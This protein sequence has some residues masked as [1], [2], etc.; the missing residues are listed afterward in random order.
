MYAVTIVNQGNKFWLKGTT[1]AFSLER[2][3]QFP[4]EESARNQLEKAKKFM[5][6]SLYKTA[7]IETI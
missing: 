4:T 3:Q 6:P 2:A 7:I 1:W 5:K